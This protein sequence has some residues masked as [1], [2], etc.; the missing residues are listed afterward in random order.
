[1]YLYWAGISRWGL[2]GGCFV[3]GGER[4]GMG[5][6]S[7]FGRVLKKACN[8]PLTSSALLLISMLTLFY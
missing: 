3:I 2:I 8:C 6:C 7:F 1:M 4:C 5:R